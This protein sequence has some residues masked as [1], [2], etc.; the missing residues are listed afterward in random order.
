MAGLLSR[1][2]DAMNIPAGARQE[3]TPIDYWRQITADPRAADQLKNSTPEEAKSLYGEAM[4]LRE[5]KKT[6]QEAIES[7]FSAPYETGEIGGW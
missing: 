7:L 1:F 3:I 6:V 4:K 5:Q 2:A